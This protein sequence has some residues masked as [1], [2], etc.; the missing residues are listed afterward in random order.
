MTQKEIADYYSRLSNG[1]KGRF[2]AFLS[3][4]LGG[5]PHTWQQKILASP[6]WRCWP[7]SFICRWII[8]ARVEHSKPL[9]SVVTIILFL[10][11]MSVLTLT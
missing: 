6:S 9:M 8:S 7:I 4:T 3:M 5:S 10:L 1:E 2:T 11:E